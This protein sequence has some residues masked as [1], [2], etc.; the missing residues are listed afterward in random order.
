MKQLLNCQLGPLDLSSS[1]SCWIMNKG[2]VSL[3]GNKMKG[4]SIVKYFDG[5]CRAK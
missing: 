5:P 2:A 4:Y 3:L 1:A